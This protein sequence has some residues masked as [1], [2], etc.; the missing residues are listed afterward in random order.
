MMRSKRLSYIPTFED[1]NDFKSNDLKKEMNDQ[2]MEIDDCGCDYEDLFTRDNTENEREDGEIEMIDENDENEQEEGLY[3]DIDGDDE[4]D[5]EESEEGSDTIFP[6]ISEPLKTFVTVN[7]ATL[8]DEELWPLSSL[9]SLCEYVGISVKGNRRCILNRLQAWNG[10]PLS[11]AGHPDSYDTRSARF[12]TVPMVF[13]EKNKVDQR[14]KTRSCLENKMEK[15][16]SSLG[17]KDSLNENGNIVGENREFDEIEGKSNNLKSFHS[18]CIIKR[19]ESLTSTPVTSSKREIKSCL[20]TTSTPRKK[21]TQTSKSAGRICFSPY[22]HVRVFVSN[23]GERELNMDPESI[24]RLIDDYDYE[25]EED[26][27]RL[28]GESCNTNTNNLVNEFQNKE[29]F[30]IT[31]KNYIDEEN[32]NKSNFWSNSASVFASNE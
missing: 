16:R 31:N 24:L 26:D 19:M 10:A 23:P 29:T 14:S 27:N 25:F 13:L 1:E 20:N 2:A 12:H 3:K 22:N 8:E 17:M 5:Y 21:L 15:N 4:N 7:P 11:G 18:P 32:S 6:L 9:K 28:L 30:L